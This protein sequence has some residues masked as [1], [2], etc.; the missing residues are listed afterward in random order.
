MMCGL[1][2]FQDGIRVVVVTTMGIMEDFN[3]I[4]V[5]CRMIR[6]KTI[7]RD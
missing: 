3:I 1:C 6:N 2:R 4:K 7:S 5:T